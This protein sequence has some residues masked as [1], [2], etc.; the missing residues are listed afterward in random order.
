MNGERSLLPA[1]RKESQLKHIY[2][3]YVQLYFNRAGIRPD[4][5][6]YIFAKHKTGS[7][8]SYSHYTRFY[9]L[10]RRVC[11][12]TKTWGISSSIRNKEALQKGTQSQSTGTEGSNGQ[13]LHPSPKWR[14]VS[15]QSRETA[16]GTKGPHNHVL[17]Q[18]AQSEGVVVAGSEG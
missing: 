2:V 15:R 13:N 11:T 8:I 3:I 4:Y 16:K 9:A 18:P 5:A 10:I 17:H 14:E 7:V 12:L 1:Q 6:N